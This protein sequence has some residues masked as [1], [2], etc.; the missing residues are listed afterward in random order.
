MT[1]K[2]RWDVSRA[3]VDMC[4][5]SGWR[6]TTLNPDMS[7]ETK[8][9]ILAERFGKITVQDDQDQVYAELIELSAASLGWAQGIT[10]RADRDRKRESRARK[11]AA[12]RAR[13]ETKRKHEADDHS[14]CDH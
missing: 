5:L 3:M 12:K 10:R 11:K 14:D 2:T 8:T 6:D 1:K 7:P 4:Q 9:A 13:K